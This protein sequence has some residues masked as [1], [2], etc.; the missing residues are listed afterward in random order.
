MSLSD[1][2]MAQIATRVAD[3]LVS[4]PGRVMHYL[5][6][7]MNKLPDDASRLKLMRTVD[8]EVRRRYWSS[9]DPH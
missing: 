6:E 5:V 2:E 1:D 7:W 3:T 4:D 8:E 9:P